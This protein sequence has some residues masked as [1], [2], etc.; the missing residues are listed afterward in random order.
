MEGLQESERAK[1]DNEDPYTP[2]C[3]PSMHYSG[4]LSSHQLSHNLFFFFKI[5]IFFSK[6]VCY[7][8]MKIPVMKLWFMKTIGY[9]YMSNALSY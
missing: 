7:R 1:E 3:G 9:F 8:N 5:R 4:I 2:E 6:T